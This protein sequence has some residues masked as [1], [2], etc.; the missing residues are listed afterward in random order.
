MKCQTGDILW[1]VL[2]HCRD[3]LL[4]PDGLLLDEWLR[5]GQARVVKHGP[6]RTVYHVTL[7]DL[8]FYLKHYRL[9]DTRARLRQLVRPSKARME[10][11]H[12]P[13]CRRAAHPNNHSAGRW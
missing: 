8:N 6:H 1:H 4:G 13:G 3:A 10:F 5:N 2:P 12:A 7:P 11:E 9:A